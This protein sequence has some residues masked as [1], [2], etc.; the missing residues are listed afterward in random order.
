VDRKAC[1]GAERAKRGD[2]GGNHPFE[3]DER[4]DSPGRMTP[5]DLELTRTPAG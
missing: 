5:V 1:L 3:A 2:R 4:V